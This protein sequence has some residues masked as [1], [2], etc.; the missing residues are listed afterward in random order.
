MLFSLNNERDYSTLPVLA[1]SWK[2][3]SKWSSDRTITVIEPHMMTHNLM[4]LQ[5]AGKA[6]AVAAK[7]VDPAFSIYRSAMVV[8]VFSIEKRLAHS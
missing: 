2:N 5:E 1:W 3:K 7:Y 8:K 6:I 4:Q